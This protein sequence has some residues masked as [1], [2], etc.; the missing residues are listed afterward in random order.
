[1]LI[2]IGKMTNKKAKVV[3][4]K[5]V[6]YVLTATQVIWNDCINKSITH[7][8]MHM[9]TSQ[10]LCINSHILATYIIHVLYIIYIGNVCTTFEN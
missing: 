1:M 9:M 7:E 5:Y 3:K 2:I 4:L 8:E 6:R 10:S